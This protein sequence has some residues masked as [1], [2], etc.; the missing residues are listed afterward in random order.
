MFKFTGFTQK[1]N[2]AVNAAIAQA[3]SLGHTYVG[4]EHLLCGLLREGSIMVYAQVRRSGASCE[5]IT[6]K[7]LETVGRGSRTELSPE[8]FTPKARRILENA[9]MEAKLSGLLQ[10]DTE[11]IL[12][13]ILKEQDSYAFRFLKQTDCDLEGLLRELSGIT[14]ELTEYQTKKQQKQT[15]TPN[16]DKFGRDLTRLAKERRLDPVIG[17]EKELARVVQILA[18]RIK[19]NPCLIGDA[20]V[21]KT[22]IAEGLAQKIIAGDVPEVLRQK[23]VIALDL[24]LMVA[25][26]KYRGD[27]EERMKS[28]MDE[29]SHS[30]NVIIFIDEIHTLIGT[31]AAEGAVDASNLLKPQLARGEFQLI[32]ATTTEEYRRF[33]EKDQALERRFQ[34]VMVPEPDEAAAIS[35]LNGLKER[36]ETFHHVC[37]TKE[38]VEAAVRLSI[39]Y[40]PEHRLP[41][42]AIDL[43]D[44]ACSRAGMKPC[45]EETG[46]LPEVTAEDIAAVLSLSTGIDAGRFTEDESAM[47]M[48]LEETIHRRVAGQEKAVSAVARASRRTRAGLREPKR[49]IGSFL[50]VGPAGVGK[51]ELTKALAEAL[52]GTEESLISLDMT[53]Y[54]EPGSVAKLIGSPPGY[55]GYDD[56]GGLTEKI[57]RRPYSV[58]LFDEIE[59]AHPDVLNLLLQLLDEGRLTDSHGRKVDF[60]N[61]VIILTSNVGAKAILNSGPMGF[62]VTNKAGTVPDAV[63]PAVMAELRAA[64]RPEFLNR[65]DEVVPF[66]KLGYRVAEQI[67]HKMLS[68][69]R[70]RLSASGIEASFSP[71][72]VEAMA[73]L[74][75]EKENGARPMKKFLRDNVE[76]PLS[77]QILSGGLCR[78]DRVFCD[79]DGALS[80]SKIDEDFAGVSP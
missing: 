54:A 35:I 37:V 66:D 39:R 1:A 2:N 8:N 65:L 19:N 77:E 29:V 71:N 68:G 30:G 9:L 79:W 50:F 4:S 61:C 80:C 11:Q 10:A 6:A 38:A 13:S 46:C 72:L 67:A 5:I 78:G 18:R 25:G 24:P 23:R 15:R 57:R 21:G 28:V 75:S 48:R 55:V 16:L 40:L 3:C 26:A 27:F 14:A 64:F 7:L 73:K 47:L 60:R 20:G 76:D 36:Y 31:G 49:P 45:R 22:A 69:L 17:R 59:K 51:T 34:S 32:G 41:D 74:C 53:E 70:E 56:A 12:L 63:R 58:V 62:S 43:M 44:E 42:K 52:F 33:I